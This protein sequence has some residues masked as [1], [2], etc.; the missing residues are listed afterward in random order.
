VLALGEHVAPEWKM[1]NLRIISF[2]QERARRRI[3][4]A[5]AASGDPQRDMR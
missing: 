2:L 4:G 3:V 1:A 5:G